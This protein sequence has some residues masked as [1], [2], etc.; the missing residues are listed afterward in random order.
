MA[1]IEF[2]E[3]FRLVADSL[4]L[5]LLR[6]LETANVMDWARSCRFACAA[7]WPLPAARRRKLC[8]LLQDVTI[9]PERGRTIAYGGKRFTGVILGSSP[10]MT[11]EAYAIAV[12]RSGEDGVGV[13]F[14]LVQ[15]DP[16][17]RQSALSRSGRRSGKLLSRF[18][19]LAVKASFMCAP[20]SIAAFQTPI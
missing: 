17:L 10:R 11:P 14:G 12:P 2:I 15:A 8:D 1:S 4:K 9:P 20:E 3:F 19:A 5:K 13:L 16:I 18:S 7:E 6:I